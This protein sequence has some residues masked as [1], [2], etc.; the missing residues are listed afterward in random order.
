MRHKMNLMNL[1]YFVAVVE[2]GSITQ[3]A[4]NL[5]TSPQAVSEQIRR[6]EGAYDVKLFQRT[7]KLQLTYAGERFHRFA[8]EVIQGERE[9]AVELDEICMHRRGKL[10]I[11]FTV[12]LQR[13][14]L[15]E[16]LPRFHQEN[17]YIELDIRTGQSKGLLSDLLA[18]H[19]DLTICNFSS[20]L[21]PGIRAAQNFDNRFCLV[22]PRE[23]LARRGMAYDPEKLT[24]TDLRALLSEEPLLMNI[25]GTQSRNL[26]DLYLDH[27]GVN[28][29]PL[30]QLNEMN[31][32]LHLCAK[33]MGIAFTFE[34]TGRICLAVKNLYDQ[35]VLVPL[36]DFD[37][38]SQVYVAYSADRHLPWTARKFLELLSLC[39]LEW[40]M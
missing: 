36:R 32:L 38:Q 29:A 11:G 33:G 14:I 30:I 3:A 20:G 6:L 37:K 34:V 24:R 4:Q 27:L 26:T 15:P 40:T 1:K 21:P 39:N 19:L 12:F 8:R 2:T 7:P 18:G 22:I 35:V 17:P 13:A 9:L 28:A 16:L 5:F 10:T 25:V 23:I 31:S